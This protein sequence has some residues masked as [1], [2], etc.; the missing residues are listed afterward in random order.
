MFSDIQ[1]FSATK[2]TAEM[3]HFSIQ[4]LAIVECLGHMQVKFCVVFSAKKILFVFFM[5]K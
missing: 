5:R 4:E 3:L 1:F 2:T